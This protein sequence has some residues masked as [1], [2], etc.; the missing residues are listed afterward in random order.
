MLNKVIL[1]GRLTA[2][3]EQKTTQSGTAV[4]SF[5]LAVDRNYKQDNGPTADFIN[6]VAWK[7]TAEFLARYFR[8]GQEVLAEGSIQI[9][10]YNDQQGVKRYVTEVQVDNVYFCGPKQEAEQSDTAAPSYPQQE[11]FTEVTGDDDL[12]F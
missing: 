6:C 1:Q 8:K 10:T 2:N 9:R 4:C 12:P 7:K 11:G 5:T 3:P